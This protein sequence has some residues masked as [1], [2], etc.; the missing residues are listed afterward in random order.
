MTAS[1]SSPQAEPTVVILIVEDEPLQRMGLIDLVEEAGFGAL[2]AIDA[3]QA[4]AI[5]EARLDVH[6]VL[7]DIDMPGAMDGLRLAATVRRRW[8]PIEIIITTAGRAPS[9]DT[10]P[11][12]AVFLPKP[13][14]RQ[15]VRTALERFAA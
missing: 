9:I 13:L 7:T 1:V 10:L 15:R 8:P 12:R 4:I 5:L 14:N 3:D 2:E 11:A 6:V